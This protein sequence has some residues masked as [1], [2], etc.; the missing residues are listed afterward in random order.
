VLGQQ[1]V[2]KFDAT[3]LKAS[4]TRALQEWL[5]KH[6]YDARPA[7]M[8]WVEPY[9]KQGWIITAFQI[10]KTETRQDQLS[11]QAVQMTFT[12]D[13]PFYPYAEPADQRQG[14]PYRFGRLLRVFFIGDQ[15]MQG[16]LEDARPWPG[17]AAWAN[18]LNS[19]Q[20]Q[21]VT[22][23]LKGDVQ[24]P[25][26]AWL[27][28]FDDA[29]SPR[30]GTSD[31]FFSP[32]ADQSTLAR[33]PVIRYEYVDLPLDAGLLALLVGGGALGVLAA[34]FLVWRRARRTA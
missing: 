10:A 17:R 11:T 22:S 7:L 13:R 28:V 20:R 33:P 32:S 25:Q 23:R 4:D 15:R 14:T 34:G 16:A 26:N 21:G 8:T 1:R 6:G 27:T 5:E 3:I 9:V 31:L 19:E 29:S 2:G 24:L 18:T 12:T 30:P